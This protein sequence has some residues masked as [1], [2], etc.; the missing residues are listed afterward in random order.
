MTSAMKLH[1]SEEEVHSV[2]LT[3]PSVLA[4]LC[5]EARH[6]SRR[7]ELGLDAVDDHNIFNTLSCSACSVS[8]SEPLNQMIYSAPSTETVFAYLDLAY[9]DTQVVFK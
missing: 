1:Y 8:L 2:N 3:R 9:P 7:L 6:R 4:Q 5:P